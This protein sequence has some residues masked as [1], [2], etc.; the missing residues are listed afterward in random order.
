MTIPYISAI[1]NFKVQLLNM[2]ALGFMANNQKRKH[3]A[4]P[5]AADSLGS[6]DVLYLSQVSDME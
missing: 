3:Q 4:K 5:I 1:F 6:I 2:E